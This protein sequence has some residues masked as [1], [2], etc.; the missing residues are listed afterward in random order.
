MSVTEDNLKIKKAAKLKKFKEKRMDSY[1][2]TIC[3]Y[4]KKYLTHIR[5]RGDKGQDSSWRHFI[6]SGAGA[7]AVLGLPAVALTGEERD[8]ETSRSWQ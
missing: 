6:P 5:T 2:H 8:A 7:E 1:A 3:I 4:T